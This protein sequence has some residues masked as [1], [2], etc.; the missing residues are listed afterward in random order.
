MSTHVYA[1]TCVLQELKHVVHHT[2][3]VEW[4]S[5][6]RSFYNDF[7]AQYATNNQVCVCVCVCA[8]CESESVCVYCLHPII[9]SPSFRLP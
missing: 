7:I 3:V 8:E 5:A 4:E 1:D 2:P 6:I 9:Q